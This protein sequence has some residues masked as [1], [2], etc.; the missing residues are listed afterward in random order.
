MLRHFNKKVPVIDLPQIVLSRGYIRGYPLMWRF[1]DFLDKE[2]VT[3]R[4]LNTVSNRCSF[5]CRAS[6][7]VK[8][9]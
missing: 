1:G 5:H 3:R 4:R 2:K 9:K 7:T 8:A 6:D